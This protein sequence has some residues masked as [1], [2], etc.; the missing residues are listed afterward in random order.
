[1]DN[2]YKVISVTSTYRSF[3]YCFALLCV[4]YIMKN[5]VL[6]IKKKWLGLLEGSSLVE[7]RPRKGASPTDPEDL[8]DEEFDNNAAVEDHDN[9]ASAAAIR[10]LGLVNE[11]TVDG[12]A[13]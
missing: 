2:T 1:M 9:T 12:P 5:V 7:I 8:D 6:Y 3:N 13:A 4:W 10:G 11:V